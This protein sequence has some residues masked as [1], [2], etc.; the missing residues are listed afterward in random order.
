MAGYRR[1]RPPLA[2]AAMAAGRTSKGT[3]A[4]GGA[5]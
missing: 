5:G 4:K 3:A 2:F 1:A